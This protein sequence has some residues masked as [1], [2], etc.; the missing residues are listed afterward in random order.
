MAGA[1]AFARGKRQAARWF[2]GWELPR[3]DA[4]LARLADNDD[5]ALAMRDDWF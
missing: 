4:W 2:F 5:C 3:V 1:G